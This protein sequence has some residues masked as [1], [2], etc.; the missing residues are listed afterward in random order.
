MATPEVAVVGLTETRKAFR[1]FGADTSWRE[2]FKG[3]YGRAAQIGQDEGQSRARRGATTLAGTHASM[4]GAAVG[5]IRGKGTT[6]A[7]TLTAFKG[8]PWGPG[9]NFG[10]T[11]RYRQFP[12]KATPDYNLYAGIA[13]KREEIETVFIEAI[14][15]ALDTAFPDG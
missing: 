1:D 8:I 10:S 13:A 7:A 2:P 9:W 4:G 6:T 3:A 5:S 14:G 11:G 12:A 15:D